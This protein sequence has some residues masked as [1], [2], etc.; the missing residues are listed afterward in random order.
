[1]LDSGKVRNV[2]DVQ[3]LKIRISALR[4]VIDTIDEA[5]EAGKLNEKKYFMNLVHAYKYDMLW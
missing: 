4:Q 5:D 1:M 3:T 2:S